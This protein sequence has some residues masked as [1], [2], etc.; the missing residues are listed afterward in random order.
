MIKLRLMRIG[1]TNQPYFRIVACEKQAPAK[2]SFID[3]LGNFD[4]MK[5]EFTID[6]EKL[7]KWIKNGAKPSDTLNNLLIK[8]GV[9]PKSKLIK[10]TVK[11]KKKE[12]KEEK[13]AKPENIESPKKP[14]I[15]TPL[16]Q[17]SEIATKQPKTDETEDKNK[18]EEINQTKDQE[19]EK[20]PEKTKETEPENTEK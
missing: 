1:K 9:W 10:K 8:E 18:T 15:E 17:K 6:K 3:I 13:P 19:V 2:A 5:H 16:E 12:Q 4:P 14:A 7:E 20:Q 11:P